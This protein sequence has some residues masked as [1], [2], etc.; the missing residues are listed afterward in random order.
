[1]HSYVR[2]CI[3]NLSSPSSPVT[4]PQSSD[5][6]LVANPF[7]GRRQEP[8]T[9]LGR[10]DLAVLAPSVVASP[11]QEQASGVLSAGPVSH[12]LTDITEV[13][14]LEI[15]TPLWA[16]LPFDSARVLPRSQATL[17]PLVGVPTEA[18]SAGLLG[19]GYS[20]PV[21]GS[22]ADAQR[23]V[24]PAGALM[25]CPELEWV[26]PQSS[27]GISCGQDSGRGGCPSEVGAVVTDTH[28]M[29]FGALIGEASS[30]EALAGGGQAWA[31]GGG[32]ASFLGMS[33]S[34]DCCWEQMAK[35]GPI[36]PEIL[37]HNTVACCDSLCTHF[38]GVQHIT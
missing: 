32:P 21:Q 26:D 20:V 22:Q 15:S 37:P 18:G 33:Q 28:L 19:T 5:N 13:A 3:V 36:L 7:F 38:I 25:Q 4:P 24:P 12:R 11:F 9:P 16:A 31:V 6:W 8:L 14:D 27:V 10:R 35:V 34:S 1:M 23:S 29:Q 30:R 2:S 17:S